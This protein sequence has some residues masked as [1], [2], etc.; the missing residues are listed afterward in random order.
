MRNLKIA[1]G[2]N[3]FQKVFKNV[4]VSWDDLCK[5]LSETHRTAETYQ[6]YI[7]APKAKQ[8]NI[9][10]IGGFVGGHLKEGKRRADSVICRSVLTLDADFA[11]PTFWEDLTMLNDFECCIYSTHKHKPNSPRLRLVVPLSRDVT[12]D[13]YEAIGRKVATYIGIDFF[14]DTTYQ[15]S[16]LMYWPSTSSNAEFVYKRQEGEWLDADEVLA[17]YTDWQDVSYWPTSSRVLEL[18]KKEQKKQ[19]DPREKEGLIGA[20]C[21]TYSISEAIEKYLPDI[22]TPSRINGRYDYVKGTTSAGLVAYDDIY[23]YSF[24]GSDPATGSL[25]NAFDLVRIHLFGE[26]DEDAKEGTPSNRQPSFKAMMDLIE[27]DEETKKET[28]KSM[29]DKFDDSVVD[30]EDLDW[31]SK[32]DMDKNKGILNTRQNAVIL[33]ENDENLKGTI[34]Y[35]LLAHSPESIKDLPWKKLNKRNKLWRDADDSQLLLYLEKKY[36][37]AFSE[38]NLKRAV[39]VV[40][41]NNSYHP[42]REYLDGIKWD[43]EP[44]IDSLLIDLFGAEDNPYTRAVTRKT[45][46]AAV[47]RIYEPGCKFDF[48]LTLVGKSGIGKS[49]LFDRLGKNWFSDSAISLSGKDSFDQ[50]QGVWILEMSEMASFKKAEVEQIKSYLSKRK[51][52]YRMAYDRRVSEIPRQCIIVGTTNNKS[53]LRDKTGNRRFWIVEV[54]EIKQKAWEILTNEAVDQIWA[55]AKH[56][57]E[58]GEKLFLSHEL[59]QYAREVQAFHMEVDPKEDAIINYLDRLLPPNWNDL[60]TWER[61]EFIQSDEENTENLEDYQV[62]N[63]VCVHE[64]LNE[65]FR[66]NPAKADRFTSNE[67]TAILENTEGWEKMKYPIRFG[68]Y[69]NQRGYKRVLLTCQKMTTSL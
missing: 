53:F 50:L 4:E 48:M 37:V 56:F 27:K 16:R 13:E 62:R 8:D 24:H 25:N 54:N 10:D 67:I 63:K 34:A 14:D 68:P 35:N 69:G 46:T 64:I 55:E 2:R 36:K 38:N 59:E 22:Y 5:K 51:D 9:K 30:D 1:T 17:T 19:S 23:A 32:L 58:S 15:A 20:F 66:I 18:H 45:L 11:K 12:S 33:I 52:N 41:D 42:I 6:E 43:G 21:R 65:V 49:T 28:V 47:A 40:A 61:R 3:R 60:S 29:L 26:L 31:V 44:R 39:D 57:Y 7:K